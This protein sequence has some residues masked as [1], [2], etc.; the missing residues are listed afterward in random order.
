MTLREELSRRLCSLVWGAPHMPYANEPV[1]SEQDRAVTWGD[2]A[3][4]CIRQ[5]E[6]AR[7]QTFDSVRDYLPDVEVH[8]PLTAAP[9]G[10]KP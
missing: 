6:W 1:C 8:E 2:L 3:D 4:E 5:M 9:E 10:W 7:R